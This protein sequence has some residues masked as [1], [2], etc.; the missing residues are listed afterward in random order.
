M[1][2]LL[3]TEYPVWMQRPWNQLLS[4]NCW[5]KRRMIIPLTYRRLLIGIFMLMAHLHGTVSH[6]VVTG[7]YPMLENTRD[8]IR[9][10]VPTNHRQQSYRRKT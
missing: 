4:A 1:L 7:T 10:S 6:T 9:G 8:T 2:R 3:G 5:I